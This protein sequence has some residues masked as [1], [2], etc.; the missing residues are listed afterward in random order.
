MLTFNFLETGENG[1]T[2]LSKQM[3]H[4]HIYIHTYI[5]IHMYIHIYAYTYTH[6]TLHT[7]KEEETF[8]ILWVIYF[9]L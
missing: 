1:L 4:I 8:S 3:V 5:Y 2:P 6:E 7:G 9:L